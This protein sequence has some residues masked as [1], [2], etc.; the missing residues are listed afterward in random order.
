MQI[1]NAQ[2]SKLNQEKS[3]LEDNLIRLS[4]IKDQACNDIQDFTAKQIAL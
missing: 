3:N 4:N 2:Y 1:I